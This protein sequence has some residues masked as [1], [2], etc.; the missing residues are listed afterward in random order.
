LRTKSAGREDSKKAGL[1]RPYL[2]LVLPAGIAPRSVFARAGRSACDLVARAALGQ[3]HLFDIVHLAKPAQRAPRSMG[4]PS[5][6]I[7]D[8]GGGCAFGY[9]SEKLVLVAPLGAF[10]RLG[11]LAGCLGGLRHLW[12][13]GNR[14]RLWSLDG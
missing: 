2:P 14:L 3:F 7:G 5:K 9:Y 1:P 11:S 4:K 8:L 12:R 13:L 10:G 6:C